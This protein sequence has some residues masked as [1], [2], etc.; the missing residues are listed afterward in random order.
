MAGQV[1]VGTPERAR[2]VQTPNEVP[3][4]VT[5]DRVEGG[6]TLEN[7]ATPA[8]LL[9]VSLG[10]RFEAGHFYDFTDISRGG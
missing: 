2:V 4:L 8:L 6:D 9:Q 10:H 7:M 3:A 1:T 5:P